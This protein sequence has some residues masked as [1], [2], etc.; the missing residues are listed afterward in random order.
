MKLKPTASEWVGLDSGLQEVH[1]GEGV[2]ELSY[3]GGQVG[4]QAMVVVV[5]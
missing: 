2:P 1:V 4:A 3:P 5:S